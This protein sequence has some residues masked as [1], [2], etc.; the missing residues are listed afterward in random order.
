MLVKRSRGSLLLPGPRRHAHATFLSAQAVPVVATRTRRSYLP[1]PCQS[2]PRARAVPICPCRASR[3][4]AHAPSL[5]AHAV[6]V[7][8]TRTRRPYLPRPCQSSPRA[9]AVPICPC[10]ASRRHAHAPSLSAHAVPVGCLVQRC[11]QKESA[12][13]SGFTL[14]ISDRQSHIEEWCLR[15]LC[16]ASDAQGGD[17]VARLIPV[18]YLFPYTTN[19]GRLFWPLRHRSS[20]A[21]AARRSQR[22]I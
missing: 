8:A 19:G 13:M 21:A 1:R 4:H 5:S 17:G 2:S 7:V 20:T 18:G 6:P 16:A 9:R 10:R 3:R 14:S 12:L 22:C 15:D 11:N